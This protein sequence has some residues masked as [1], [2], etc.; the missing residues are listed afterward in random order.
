[1][2]RHSEQAAGVAVE[3]KEGGGLKDGR[4]LNEG[5]LGAD[6]DSLLVLE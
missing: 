6:S 5:A 2:E 1:M 4:D 3:T